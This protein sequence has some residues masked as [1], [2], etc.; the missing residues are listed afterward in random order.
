MDSTF[1]S[2]YTENKYNERKINFKTVFY[3][4]YHIPLWYQPALVRAVPAQDGGGG[5]TEGAGRRG[6]AGR[7]GVDKHVLWGLER[8]AVDGRPQLSSRDSAAGRLLFKACNECNNPW[9]SELW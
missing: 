3:S 8:G 2:S 4:S 7:A 9:L 6:R 1:S 5:E